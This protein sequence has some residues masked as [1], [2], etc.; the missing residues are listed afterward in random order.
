MEISEK[1]IE[2]K[3][4]AN[5]SLDSAWSRWTTHEGLKTFF[6]RDNKIEL[7]E[8]GCFEI[9]F[10]MENPEGLRG[11]EGCRILTFTP[12]EMI[13]FTWNAPPDFKE[14]R[15]SSY[16]TAVIVNFR[17]I[18]GKQTEISIRHLGWPTDK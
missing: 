7:E 16:F 15:E 18:N 9:Y 4:I 1:S 8:G 12:G 14:V 10:L 2:K 13:S 3:I 6:G 17:A 11:S 5:C